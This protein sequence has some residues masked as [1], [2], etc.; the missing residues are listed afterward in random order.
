MLEMLRSQLI[1]ERT[2]CAILGLLVILLWLPRLQG[3]IDLRWDGGVY[4]V[5]GTSLAEGKGYRLLNEPGEIQANQY[6]PLFPLIIAAH[7]LVLGTSDPL[8]VGRFLRLSSFLVFATYIFAIYGLLRRH[9]S[10]AY[11]FFGTIVCLLNVNTYF[12]SDV[13]FPDLLYGLVIVGFL[14]AYS[15]EQR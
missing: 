12:L 4:Y 8:V 14:L 5:L 13:C 6:P 7:Q 3:P 9:L 10:S 2:L 11:A 1:Q 15:S